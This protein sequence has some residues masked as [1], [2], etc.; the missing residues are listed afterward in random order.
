MNYLAIHVHVRGHNGDSK[1]VWDGE[2]FVLESSN[3]M[4]TLISSSIVGMKSLNQKMMKIDKIWF[5]GEWLYGL[6]DDGKTYRQSLLW[7]KDLLKASK[8]ERQEYERRGLMPDCF[9][10]ISMDLKNRL[11]SARLKFYSKSIN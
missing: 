8:T 10:T 9:A 7:Y 5:E 3:N 4:K 2:G 6:G 1:F 11:K